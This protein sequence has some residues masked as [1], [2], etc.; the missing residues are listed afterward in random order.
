MPP[1]SGWLLVLIEWGACDDKRDLAFAD[2]AELP[3]CYLFDIGVAGDVL[4]DSFE[5]GLLLLELLHAVGGLL[6]PGADSLG[7][8]IA[9]DGG[10]DEIACYEKAHDKD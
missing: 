7:M 2:I 9:G 10:I 5:V 6:L 4:M 3:T 1:F 8:G